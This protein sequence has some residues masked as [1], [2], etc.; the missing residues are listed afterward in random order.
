[1]DIDRPIRFEQHAEDVVALL[2]HLGIGQADFFGESFGG[3]I[4]AIIAVRYPALVGRVAT[5]GAVFGPFQDAFKPEMLATQLSLSAG[6]YG[7]QFQRENYKKVAPDPEYWPTIWGKVFSTQWGGLSGAELA[8][9]QA[10]FLIAVGDHDFVRLDHAVETFR[11]I[12]NAELAVIPDAGHFVLNAQ[13]EKVMPAIEAF[14]D[15]P[16]VKIP[17]ATT[18]TGYHPGETR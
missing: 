15:A 8:S 10:P 12:P 1:V 14:L 16:A 5:Y 2:K 18:Q 11:T 13:P 9:I 4:A 6:A 7:M 3:L 17:F